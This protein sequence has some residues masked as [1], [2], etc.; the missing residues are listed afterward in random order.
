LAPFEA[1][2]RAFSYG[3]SDGDVF[4]QVEFDRAAAGGSVGKAVTADAAAGVEYFRDV[5]A[6][7]FVRDDIPH[8]ADHC[9]ELFA[10]KEEFWREAD[11]LAGGGSARPRPAR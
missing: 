5:D 1:S 10:L 4:V 9:V 11:G 6:L 7:R 3:K 2:L 8:E